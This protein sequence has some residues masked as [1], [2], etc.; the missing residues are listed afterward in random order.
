M[1]THQLRLV[2]D[3]IN[4]LFPSCRIIYVSYF[5]ILISGQDL[6]GQRGIHPDPPGLL[7]APDPSRGKYNVQALLLPSPPAHIPLYMTVPPGPAETCLSLYSDV[8]LSFCLCY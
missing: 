4:N 7:S 2:K 5:S 8:V 3:K 6:T 1:V